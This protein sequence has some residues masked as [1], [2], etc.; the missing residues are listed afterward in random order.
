MFEEAPRRGDA[1]ERCVYQVIER[2]V[3]ADGPIL[4]IPDIE[5]AVY[6]TSLTASPDDVL[7]WN[8]DHGTMEQYHSEV[9]TDVD[10][11]RLPSGKPPTRSDS[12]WRV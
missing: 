2:T 12:S 1:P 8:P 5:I 3:T 10:L 4:L 6:W 11:E 9:K 7:P